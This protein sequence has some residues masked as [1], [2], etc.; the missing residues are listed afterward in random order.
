[1]KQ[2]LAALLIFHYFF[3]TG[4]IKENSTQGKK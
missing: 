4:Q 3:V 1:M 2:H